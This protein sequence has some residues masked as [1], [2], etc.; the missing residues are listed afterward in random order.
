MTAERNGIPATVV[1]VTAMGIPV[2]GPSSRITERNGEDARHLVPGRRQATSEGHF[3]GGIAMTSLTAPGVISRWMLGAALLLPAAVFI[4]EGRA[5]QLQAQNFCFVE[6]PAGDVQGRDFETSCAFLGVPYAA[7]T[8]GNNRWRP[9]QPRAAWAPTVVDARSGVP[10]CPQLQAGM[11]AGTEDCLFMNIWTRDLRPA[12]PA[13]VI[14]WLPT[15]GFTAASA[16]FAATNGRRLA[17]ETGTVVVSP[18]YRLGPLGF[19]AHSALAQEDALH[20]SSGNYGLLDQQA[21][22]R[23]VRDNIAS[24]GGDPTKVTLAGTSAGGTSVGLHLVAPA[25]GG[26]FQRAVLQSA[27]LAT[28]RLTTHDEFMAT[29]D[30]WV[31]ALGCTNP[32]QVI[33]CMRSKSLSQVLTAMPVGTLQVIA[34]SNSVYWEPLVDGIVIPDQP[35]A[36]LELGAFAHVPTIVGINRDEGWGSFTSRFISQS[37]PT[38]V[39]PEQYDAWAAAEFGSHAS[40]V[41]ALYPAADFESPAAAMAQVV[42]DAQFV[43]EARRTARLIERTRTSTYLYSYEHLIDDLSPDYVLHGVESNIL[44]GNAYVPPIF[45]AHT[46]DARDED[47]HTAMAGYWSRFAASGNPNRGGGLAT[48]WPPFRRPRGGGRGTDRYLILA[49]TISERAR[50]RNRQ[51]DFFEPLFLRSLLGGLP[52]SAE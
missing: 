37:F 5:V 1:A 29:G 4:A 52:A 13:P 12:R 27:H 40:S 28:L 49:S 50:L 3:K 48:S 15:G 36:L 33:V 2:A 32:L 10:T 22:L 16:N 7:S 44:F 6:L 42:G 41:L 25:S 39:T 8:A 14:V 47:L 23:W 19:L 45:P 20:P 18:N 30:A 9:P 21:A 17:E 38:G 31:A 26:L 51:C 43:C 11:A 34:P 24:F 46:L 35:R